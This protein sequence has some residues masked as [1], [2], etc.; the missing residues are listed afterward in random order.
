MVEST[1]LLSSISLL[2]SSRHH[3]NWKFPLKNDSQSILKLSHSSHFYLVSINFNSCIFWIHI[4]NIALRIDTE[5]D[6]QFL[7][8]DQLFLK[9]KHQVVDLNWLTNLI[10]QLAQVFPSV[11]WVIGC[12]NLLK[13]TKKWLIYQV[14]YQ[15]K[16]WNLLFSAG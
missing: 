1:F 3:A 14:V 7:V 9:D 2:S 5:E 12:D 11:N 15:I 4:D 10:A 8:R 16:Y 13:I 6:L